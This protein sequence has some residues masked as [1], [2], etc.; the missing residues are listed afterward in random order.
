MITDIY[1][2]KKEARIR[3]INKKS[4][5]V[6]IVTF[7]RVNNPYSIVVMNEKGETPVIELLYYV[8]EALDLID[9]I[10]LFFKKWFKRRKKGEK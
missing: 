9:R 5:K 8:I 1:S 6:E 4:K 7:V 3:I 10:I 2:I